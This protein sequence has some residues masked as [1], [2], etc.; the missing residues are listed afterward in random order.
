MKD[1]AYGSK[2]QQPRHTSV[3]TAFTDIL[4]NCDPSFITPASPGLLGN[5]TFIGHECFWSIKPKCTV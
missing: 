3:G 2:P 4:K 5:R 1:L